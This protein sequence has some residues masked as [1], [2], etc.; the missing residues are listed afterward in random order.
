MFD[1]PH[2]FISSDIEKM[3]DNQESARVC[4]LQQLCDT[5][6]G[7]NAFK[8]PWGGV[9]LKNCGPNGELHSNE[10]IKEFKETQHQ[11]WLYLQLKIFRYRD[12]AFP[13]FCCPECE[14]MQAVNNFSL[15]VF[16]K[17]RPPPP[18]FSKFPN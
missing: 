18:L 4:Y 15:Y 7:N 9:I 5:S 11:L 14:D 13:I 8:T 10:T 3:E 17:Y 2:L 1:L 12:H 16:E 6:M